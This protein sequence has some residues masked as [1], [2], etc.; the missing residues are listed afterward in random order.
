MFQEQY[1]TTDDGLKLYLRDYSAKDQ[2]DINLPIICL[3]GLS[4]NTRDF[5]KLAMHLSQVTPSPHRVISLDYR[6][7]GNSDWDDKKENYNIV[8]EAQDVLLAM[9]HLNI[10]KA[11]FI[12]TSRGGLIIHILATINLDA[13]SAVVFNDIGPVIELAGLLEIQDY[14]EQSRLPK[15]WDDAAQMQKELHGTSF[16]DLSDQDWLDMA[17]EIY[18][19]K[20]NKI[21]PDFDVAVVNSIK[22]LD[23]AT[24]LPTLWDQFAL[25]ANNPILTI[26]GENSTLF[27]EKTLDAMG[28]RHANHKAITVANQGHP[29]NLHTEG[30]AEQIAEFLMK[31]KVQK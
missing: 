19:E 24:Q 13:I 18:V 29:P 12:G 14:L 27:S 22:T 26:R 23:S 16:T 2:S 30:L 20:N 7:R 9:S 8:R 25:L 1:Y 31:P 10:P 28:Q 3:P 6:G 17:D 4:R 15:S 21:L 5:H 11:N